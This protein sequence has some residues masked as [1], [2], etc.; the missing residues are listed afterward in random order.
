MNVLFARD[1]II[2]RKRKLLNNT[3]FTEILFI[4]SDSDISLRRRS[5]S[6]HVCGSVLLSLS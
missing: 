6:G 5:S 1:C 2:F 4:D 3:I